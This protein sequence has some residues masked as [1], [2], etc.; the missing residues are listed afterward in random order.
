MSPFVSS[1]QKVYCSE[2]HYFDYNYPPV[3]EDPGVG[4]ITLYH[5]I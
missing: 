2:L 1:L 4:S 3:S 5:I